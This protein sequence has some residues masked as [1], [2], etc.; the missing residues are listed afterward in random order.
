MWANFNQ[1]FSTK[2]LGLITN[3]IMQLLVD[4]IGSFL[5]GSHFMMLIILKNRDFWEDRK[6][7]WNLKYQNCFPPPHPSPFWFSGAKINGNFVVSAGSSS[8]SPWH[9]GAGPAQSQNGCSFVPQRW[10][11]YCIALCTRQTAGSCRAEFKGRPAPAPAPAADW[12]CA[13]LVTAG[14][15]RR[16]SA[17]PAPRRQMRRLA[18]GRSERS[19]V[20]LR[21]QPG[22]CHF[23]ERA[24]RF[25]GR[26]VGKGRERSSNS[27]WG[28]PVGGLPPDFAS[29][30]SLTPALVVHTLRRVFLCPSLGRVGLSE[31]ASTSG[32]SK[33]HYSKTY[34]FLH[35]SLSL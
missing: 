9:L 3:G 22:C 19:D 21:A 20:G 29:G 26:G 16:P 10:Q 6:S 17:G 33:R 27:G 1:P 14:Q 25:G 8:V 2:S 31:A 23:V 34:Q 13:R 12:L 18:P 11:T 24:S 35:F 32:E 4:W 15:Q 28:F 5:S 7:N 30:R